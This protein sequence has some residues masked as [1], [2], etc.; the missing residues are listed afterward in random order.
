VEYLLP[1]IEQCSNLYS[2]YLGSD[3]FLFVYIGG[4]VSPTPTD[5][6][7][8]FL[9]QYWRQHW[10]QIELFKK[11][12]RFGGRR[13]V[14][15]GGEMEKNLGKSFR[16]RS[17]NSIKSS[18]LNR[19][20]DRCVVAWF[21]ATENLYPSLKTLHTPIPLHFIR[22]FFGY[23]TDLPSGKCNARI[24][25]G[26]SFVYP[27]EVPE[28]SIMVVNDIVSPTGNVMT[29]GCGVIH[30]DLV[31]AI[32]YAVTHG[33]V[34]GNIRTEFSPL[35]S[36]IQVRCVSKKGLFKGCL[37]VTA[38][39][40]LCPPGTVIFRESMKKAEG[41]PVYAT[42]SGLIQGF[43]NISV[44]RGDE[45]LVE[46]KTKTMLGVV[47][48]FEHPALLGK[49]SQREMSDFK[50]RLNRSLCL[51]LSYLGVKRENLLAMM[52][53]E[54]DQ[55]GSDGNT[56]QDAFNLARNCLMNI[57]EGGLH[58][59][60]QAEVDDDE[61]TDHTTVGDGGGIFNDVLS[62]SI[63]KQSPN[64][65]KICEPIYSW[66][67]RHSVLLQTH[68]R[69]L[70]SESLAEKIIQF[71]DAG[72]NVDEEPY[73]M[74]LYNRLKMQRYKFLSRC[75]IS[76]R[77]SIYLVG[78][79]DPY[80]L[81][82]PGEVFI[83]PP[84]DRLDLR[85]HTSFSRCPFIRSKVLV[86]RHPMQHPGDIRVFAA[87]NH[88]LLIQNSRLPELT[89]GG[90]IFFSTKGE[91]SPGDEMSGGDYDGDRYLVL[92][93]EQIVD[94]TFPIPPNSE[95]M[96]RDLL[97]HVLVEK[98]LCDEVVRSHVVADST[99]PCH[100]QVCLD[101]LGCTMFRKLLTDA[102]EQNVGRYSNAWLAYADR[103]PM[104]REALLCGYIVRIALDAAKTGKQIRPSSELLLKAPR[105]R[106]LR[107]D[108]LPME[109]V[110][111]GDNDLMIRQNGTRAEMDEFVSPEDLFQ[112]DSDSGWRD[113]DNN[114]EDEVLLDEE[115]LYNFNELNIAARR[116]SIGFSSGR[117]SGGSTSTMT[118]STT[119]SK[120]V[121]Q[122]MFE[123]VTKAI[124]TSPVQI[125]MQSKL[126]I[127]WDL[128][129]VE[130]DLP[131]HNKYELCGKSQDIHFLRERIFQIFPKFHFE[132]QEWYCHVKEYKISFWKLY[133]NNEKSDQSHM[134]SLELAGQEI[135]LAHMQLFDKAASD[136]AKKFQ[137]CEK[138]ARLRLAGIVYLATYF[139]AS[140]I[141]D[142]LTDFKIK[143]SQL[144]S[145]KS[146]LSINSPAQQNV[147]KTV[148]L[149]YCWE[150]CGN[151]LHHN[152]KQMEKRR[153]LVPALQTM[154]RSVVYML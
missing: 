10:A 65:V 130:D 13:Y 135:R 142:S 96:E 18:Q 25:L 131:E 146:R 30:A 75:N 97:K 31:T 141:L 53:G 103:D 67:D 41:S 6:T 56:T 80:Q 33:S 19:P 94:S 112:N 50:A 85:R 150:I 105:L 4:L 16:F 101:S 66:K 69:L 102:Q 32:P 99:I 76:I 7:H 151:E 42:T 71:V 124:P 119:S 125:T 11:G 77:N 143:E 58:W 136:F 24:K 57:Q 127:D 52:Q 107:D 44:G 123:M 81:L 148:T 93:G 134:I 34:K 9:S 111:N 147:N 68:A 129:I 45:W 22:N 46:T 153:Q 108:I 110:P 90:V 73:F 106:H 8:A 43:E 126:Q 109:S 27:I 20:I 79:P 61:E 89:S 54:I 62:S 117:R 55:L 74:Q 39:C 59:Y 137:V 51:L 128:L 49:D 114:T 21:V 138:V 36:M 118:I 3:R 63:L 38:D 92:F 2:H 113:D 83:L 115:L 26:F 29:D 28:S 1:Q 78:A 152:K 149:N 98:S 116:S 35:P 87:V 88:P 37:M 91:R 121:V 48:S 154:L 133:V 120:S 82:E 15:L 47:D 23:L 40:K 140:L 144:E 60:E 104:S 14:F 70:P 100:C 17:V 72:H 64:K 139:N 145:G 5:S 95:D 86:T 132:L 84:N 122:E 12:L